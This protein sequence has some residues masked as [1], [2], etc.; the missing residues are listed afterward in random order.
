MVQ[1]WNRV[2]KNKSICE[3]DDWVECLKV[4]VRRELATH[5]ELAKCAAIEDITNEIFA[6]P[7]ARRVEA[8]KQM[9]PMLPAA[10]QKDFE[11]A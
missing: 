7:R 11:E 10:A 3:V 8:L 1:P 4:A 6:L 2:V 5:L 9:W